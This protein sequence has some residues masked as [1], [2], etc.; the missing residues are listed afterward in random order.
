[1]EMVSLGAEGRLYVSKDPVRSKVAV[2]EDMAR[3]AV[4]PRSVGAAAR[5]RRR[6]DAFDVNMVGGPAIATRI[7]NSVIEQRMAQ[8]LETVGTWHCGSRYC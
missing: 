8:E 3:V 4:R 2:S 7:Q 1:M 6:D 5:R